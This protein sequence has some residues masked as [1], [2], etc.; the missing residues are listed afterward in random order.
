MSRPHRRRDHQ[1][2]DARELH[3][4]VQGAHRHREV[5]AAWCN[6]A[7]LFHRGQGAPHPTQRAVLPGHA[8]GHA[9]LP[10]VAA[11]GACRPLAE[12]LGVCCGCT[13]PRNATFRPLCPLCTLRPLYLHWAGGLLMGP[14]C[15]LQPLVWLAAVQ[16]NE[17]MNE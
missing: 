6:G 13:R 10:F 1:D 17:W 12:V 9:Q 8:L 5:R 15:I 4:D 3:P 11:T 14:L 2:V 7:P 16:M